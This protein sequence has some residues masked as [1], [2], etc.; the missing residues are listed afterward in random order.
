[1]VIQT[2]PALEFQKATRPHHITIRDVLELK[3]GDPVTFLCFD[4]NVWDLVLKEDPEEKDYV[5]PADLFF[6]TGYHLTFE[7]TEGLAG[8]AVM[9]AG[10][11]KMGAMEPFEFHIE[12]APGYWYPL[13]D[14]HLPMQDPQGLGSFHYDAPKHWNTFPENTRVG[15]RGPMIRQSVLEESPAIVWRGFE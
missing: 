13:R 4:R 12:Y 3:V 1:M 7:R 8:I 14:N 9:S 11:E 2:I 5:T 6:A 15:W 10:D